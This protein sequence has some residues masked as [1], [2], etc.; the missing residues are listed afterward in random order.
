MNRKQ[1]EAN[2]RILLKYNIGHNIE[3]AREK[4]R[5]LIKASKIKE[6]HRDRDILEMV[7]QINEESNKRRWKSKIEKDY[8]FLVTPSEIETQQ[9]KHLS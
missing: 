4:L 1:F 6:K 7:E 3:E 2:A 5:A 9:L 8:E